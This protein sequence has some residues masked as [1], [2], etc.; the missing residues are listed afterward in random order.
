VPRG[1]TDRKAVLEAATGTFSKKDLL[2]NAEQYALQCLIDQATQYTFPT[3]GPAVKE[4]T[5]F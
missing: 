3:D 4:M 5:S 1:K 2:D